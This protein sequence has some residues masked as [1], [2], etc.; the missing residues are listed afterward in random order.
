[1]LKITKVIKL[2]PSKPKILLGQAS[3][4]TCVELIQ[5]HYLDCIGRYGKRNVINNNNQSFDVYNKGAIKSLE[6]SIFLET[7]TNDYTKLKA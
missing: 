3:I 1:M 4:E 2:T 6:F 5:L 7:E